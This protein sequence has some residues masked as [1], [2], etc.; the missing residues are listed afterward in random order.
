[1]HVD[2]NVL[3]I[4]CLGLLA[5]VPACNR[6]MQLWFIHQAL[7]KTGLAGAP[8]V[9]SYT[10]TKPNAL[11]P[12]EIPLLRTEACAFLGQDEPIGHSSA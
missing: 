4:K 8:A 10:E 5:C 11:L 7:S 3:E 1:M 12:Q 6:D 9:S 2:M